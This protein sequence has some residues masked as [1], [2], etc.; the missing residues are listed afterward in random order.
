[1]STEQPGDQL[2]AQGMS[3]RRG[4][5]DVHWRRDPLILARLGEVE[6]RY[7]AK[8]SN[9][10]IA[11]ALGVDEITVRRDIARLEELW[12]ERAAR[13]QDE[14]RAAVLADLENVKALALAAARFDEAAERAV[15]YGAV[16]DEIEEKGLRLVYDEHGRIQFRGNKA[17]ALA[18]AR[19]AIMDAAKVQGLVIDK[20]MPSDE[21]GNVLRP[22]TVIEAQAL[23]VADEESEDDGGRA[24]E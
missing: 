21:K 13:A 22:I 11:A 6:T 15:L 1:V 4:R 20:I 17:A 9:V 10:A 5:K 12:K 24:A 23:P 16:P 3:K 8:W 2:D 7:L 14:R 18:V 19:A